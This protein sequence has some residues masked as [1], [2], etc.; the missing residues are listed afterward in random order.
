V[1]ARRLLACFATAATGAVMMICGSAVA[2]P[3]HIVVSHRFAQPPTTADCESQI[4][5]A[6][7]S[8]NQYQQ[9]YDM[10]PLYSAGL[11]GAGRTIVLVDSFGS[12]TIRDDLNTFDSDFG[13]PAP[14]NFN[15]ITPAG[16]PPPFDPTNSDMVNWAVE[17]SL[18][19]EYAHA[20]APGANILLVETPVSET[21]GTVGF[22]QIVAAENF[23]INHG[24]GDVISQ[25]FGATEPT[26]PNAQSIFNL[27]G[28][29]FNALAHRVTVLGSSGDGGP[30]DFDTDLMDYFPFR[31]NSWP[32]SD[33]LVTS[34]GG[35]QLHLD[36]HGNRVAPDNVWND[37]FN[38]DVN[39]G[40]PSA[41][42]S[43][44][45]RSA[46]FGRP[47]YQDSVANVTRGARGTPD[48][49]M[50]AAV[51]GAAL[52][53]MSFG[54]LPAP[55]YFLIGGTSEASPLFSGVVAVADQAAG[56]RLGLLNPTLYA[57]GDG[58][59]SGIDD[60]IG[61]DTDVA[62]TN[63]TQ[64]PG[65]HRVKGFRAKRGYDLA[66]G[67]GTADGARLIQQIASARGL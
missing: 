55:G 52:V 30:T 44:G 32:S 45:G 9:A 19:V 48:V 60:V 31:V 40:T 41:I 25:S 15:I 38:T 59:R 43:G 22:P 56:H 18:D 42:A 7:Y 26:F 2:E 36:A 53:Y 62:F 6:C 1:S 11:N 28:A 23:V 49:S 17:T 64:F 66:T 58:P 63:T 39:G 4:G 21:E 5:I 3:M 46:V 29:I 14:P 37:S 67:L 8:P 65:T 34:V 35:T 51:D 10:K 33:P 50:S 57:L 27:R 47:F 24:L 12:P 20:M 54:G 61:G 13:L 16:T